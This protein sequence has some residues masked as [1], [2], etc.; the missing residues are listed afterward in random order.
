M[1]ESGAQV[2][3]TVALRNLGRQ[4]VTV[5]EPE[6]NEQGEVIGYRSV[7]THR[8]TWEVECQPALERSRQ[9]DL[10]KRAEAI[11]AQ[12]QAGVDLKNSDPLQAKAQVVGAIQQAR[13]MGEECTKAGEGM[14]AALVSKP[15][16][17]N[18]WRDG[19]LTYQYETE[20]GQDHER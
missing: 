9:T 17:A 18:A 11:V 19:Q 20:H 6:R 5:E 2:G 7:Q 13:L 8:N 1:A 4:P 14:P 16:L 15:S 10:E 12:L 3:D